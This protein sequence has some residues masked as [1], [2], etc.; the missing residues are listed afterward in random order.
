M[1]TFPNYLKGWKE[2]SCTVKSSFVCEY[3][4][5]RILMNASLNHNLAIVPLY[6]CVIVVPKMAKQI[7]YTSVACE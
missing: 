2:N 1:I 3:F 4:K 5:R 6:E 7:D